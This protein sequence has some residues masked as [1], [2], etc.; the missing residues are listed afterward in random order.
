MLS[1]FC[2]KNTIFCMNF[3]KHEN[4]LSPVF[5]LTDIDN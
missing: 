3:T 4:F 2:K 5:A 1:F